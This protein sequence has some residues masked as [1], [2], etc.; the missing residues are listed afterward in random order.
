MTTLTLE[1][2]EEL[3]AA[4]RSA[5]ARRHTSPPRLAREL[6]ERALSAEVR[7]ANA[8]E[9][10]LEHWRG[11]L[12]EPGGTTGDDVRLEHLLKKHLR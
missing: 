11:S 5:S 12:P 2:P 1:I 3:D 7:P 10:W 6:L 8:A 9:Q 4:L